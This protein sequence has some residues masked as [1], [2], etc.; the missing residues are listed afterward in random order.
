VR[1]LGAAGALSIASVAHGQPP[2]DIQT[3]CLEAH[4]QAQVDRLDG[5]LRAAVARLRVCADVVCPAVIREDCVRWTE[6]VSHDLP[7]VIFAAQSEDGDE[8]EVRVLAN[9]EVVAPAL[10]GK[11]VA[12][13]PGAYRLRFEHPAAA[14]VEVPVVLRAGEHDRVIAVTFVLR[15]GPEP[16][17]PA[18]AAP[19]GPPSPPPDLGAPRPVIWPMTLLGSLAVVGTT[20]AIVFGVSARRDHD[21]AERSCAPVCDDE[22]VDAIRR[23]AVVADVSTMVAVGSAATASILLV[24]GHARRRDRRTAWGVAVAPDGAQVSVRGALR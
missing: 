16:I 23:R 3:R 14:P 20:S 21:D 7:T 17:A 4:E 9:G 5:K 13:D 19:M 10:D 1:W 12:L 11:P 6:A 24:V 8:S 2:A 18:P 22:T 15:P